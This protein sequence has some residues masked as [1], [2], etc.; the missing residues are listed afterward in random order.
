MFLLFLFFYLSHDVW[1]Q[2]QILYVKVSTDHP[3]PK[4]CQIV[5][6][7][8]LDW[9]ANNSNYSFMS[10][11]QM[12]FQDGVH[13]LQKFVEVSDCTNFTMIG[14]GS[15]LRS[16]DGYSQP[17]SI[18]NCSRETNSG[19]FFSYSSN[20]HISN[21]ELRSCS[22]QYTLKKSNHTFAGSLVFNAVKGI[23]LDQILIRNA[24]GYGL[25]T[26]DIWGTIHVLDSAFL[27]TRKHKDISDSA[28]A[29]FFFGEQTTDVDTT[30]VIRSSW[31]MYGETKKSYNAAGGL[32]VFIYCPN[33]HVRITDVTAQGNIGVN[34]GNVALYLVA[35]TLNS[36]D[37]V[38][39][40]CQVIDGR[41]KKGGGL[42]FW[43]KQDQTSE[44][45]YIEKPVTSNNHQLLII[46]NTLFHNN[47]ASSTGG[48][49]YV[50][51]YNDGH[52]GIE[53]Q[54]IISRCDF[55]H[56]TGNGAAM[57][58]IQH[59]SLCH[60]TAH[61]FQTSIE[62]CSFEH[63]FMPSNEDGPILDFIYIDVMMINCRIVGSNST[64]ISLRNTYLNLLGDILFEN[65]SARVGGAL[66]VCEASLIFVHNR[67]HVHFINNSAQKGGAIYV[68]QSCTDTWPLCFIQ[69]AISSKITVVEFIKLMQ[70][71]FINN[72]A[73]IA[74]DALYGGD[75]DV[76]ST[77]VPYYIN[78]T[79]QYSS[80]WYSKE[81]FLHGI[82]K[83]YQKHGPSWISSNPRG[84]CFCN[85]SDFTS[86]SSVCTNT[87]DIIQR[88]PGQ[89]FTVSIL[90]VGQMNGT[91]LGI[92]NVSL[93]DEER[94]S[95]YLTSLDG[96]QQ[97]PA[98]CVQL[99]YILNS[100]RESAQIDF[101]PV[102]PE[103]ATKYET[104]TV[105]LTIQLLRCPLGFQLSEALPYKCIC[106]P[107][108]LK[109]ATYM[110]NSQIICDINLQTISFKQKELWF[111]CHDAKR[112]NVSSTCTNLVATSESCDFY[113]RNAKS[114]SNTTVDISVADIDS[115]C[116]SGH[117]GILCGECMSEYSRVL[118]GTFECQ[119]NCTNKNLPLILITFVASGFI[120]II[121][122]IALNLTI[123]E[124]T[125]NGLL[126]YTNIIQTYFLEELSG[127]GKLC[128][129][130]ISW[131]NLT[132]GI[133][134]CFYKG[135]DAYQQIWII[136]A[137]V[138]YYLAIF[139]LIIFLS[140]K[141]TFF[142][143]LFGRNIIKV[144][145]TILFLLYSNLLFA[146][147]NTF[148]YAHLSIVSSNGTHYT[149]LAWYYDGNVT[150]FGFKHAML[151]ITAL[152]CTIV[153]LI[154]V[155]S[156]LLIQ[157]LQKQNHL[158]C[159]R[160]VE[161][162]R[163]FYEACNGPCHD[164]YRFWPGFLL[165]MRSGLYIIHSL[166]PSYIDAML[167]IKMLIT[168]AVL[169]IIMSLSCIFPKGVYKKWPLNVLEFSFYLNL[170]ITSAI[171]GLSYNR[172]LNVSAVYTSV[173]ISA[174]TLLGI[175]MY[176]L[177]S[178]IKGTMVY[179]KI[180]TRC[181]QF[182]CSARQHRDEDFDDERDTL[183]P[184]Q[185]MPPVVKFNQFRELL[186]DA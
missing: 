111:G 105:T 85:E 62:M 164:N 134:V 124:G 47:T 129:A 55:T 14:N 45:H 9:Y 127:V 159:L 8:T 171:L 136:F 91:T 16:S 173:S 180:A 2:Q 81:I 113:C 172:H 98:K 175:L 100:N 117:T 60:H 82:F 20:I 50:A 51:Y 151:F 75:L 109:L 88:Y 139:I 137:Q 48:A 49:I 77:I 126:V 182:L 145:A 121:F 57:Q 183:L 184:H 119:K 66:K 186:V 106:N 79:Q 83:S 39:S 67:T 143:R 93:V 86:E 144:L 22:G 6:C 128:W 162:L 174:L 185:P 84:V 33:V 133:K 97:S 3:C 4:N 1:S 70:V 156:L 38:I 89:I 135:M 177:H 69:V 5:E 149:K 101:K 110:Y 41:A 24:M 63:N 31:F 112:Q 146:T 132:L 115:Q 10:N 118:G 116:L 140:R 76:C 12:L 53:G 150:Y 42:R 74:G 170:C 166:I 23:T 163:P 108:F 157:C 25:H 103:I 78:H 68:Q 107:L 125:L 181:S 169:V 61:W 13:L 114:T 44:K 131:I 161:R 142:T 178:R 73:T 11:K 80:Y 43:S 92:I 32:N 102:T 90:T 19:L 120:V 65:N 7:Q 94:G 95:H 165:F 87:K 153:M 56:N 26:T 122:I 35:F 147:L 160:W 17:T 167:R 152:V 40:H 54:V 99:R 29:K 59:K 72:S 46:N 34:G 104:E 15:A 138:F 27:Y 148:R 176:H 154:F 179:K 28:N 168:T 123:T 37:I 71:E 96:Q 141:F 58:I 30:L 64:A 18:V 130:F 52:S 21:L 155:F 36:S 158:W